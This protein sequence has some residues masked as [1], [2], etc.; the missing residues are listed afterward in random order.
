MTETLPAT[1]AGTVR[2]ATTRARRSH[3]SAVA[4]VAVGLVAGF[5]AGP[6]LLG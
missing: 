6:F 4:A 1:P 5:A 3:L 2:R